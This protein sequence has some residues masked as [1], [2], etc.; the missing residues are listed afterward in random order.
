MCRPD[1]QPA[2]P[3]VTE[4]RGEPVTGV[5]SRENRAWLPENESGCNETYEYFKEFAVFFLLDWNFNCN[6]M[7]KI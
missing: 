7:L 4:S 6:Y 2:P 3:A 5:K 1:K